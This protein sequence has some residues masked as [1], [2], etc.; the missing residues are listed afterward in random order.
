[1]DNKE[2]KRLKRSELLEIILMLKENEKTLQEENRDL[3]EQLTRLTKEISSR[4]SALASDDVL[5]RSF[6]EME[7]TY[8]AFKNAAKKYCVLM[9]EVGADTASGESEIYRGLINNEEKE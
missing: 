8:L 9:E 3:K 4:R 5:G 1:M 6:E 2:L 7:K